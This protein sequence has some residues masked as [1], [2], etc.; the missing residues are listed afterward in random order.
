VSA[1]LRLIAIVALFVIVVV[2]LSVGSGNRRDMSVPEKVLVEVL[3]TFQEGL[4]GSA[5]S[6]EDLWRGYF[7]LIGLREENEALKKAQ[8]RLRGQVDQLREAGQANERL[9]KLLNFKSEND[10]T[11]L[12][13][14][15]I[16]WD[17]SAWFKSV[18]INRGSEDGLRPGL[19]VV[20]DEGVIGRVV[21]VSPRF[22]KVLLMIDYN[23]SIDA[24]VR[25]TRVRGILA[26]RSEKTCLLKYVLKNDEVS[27]DD[28]L[29]TS[30]LD[31][32]F[33]GGLTLGTVSRVKAMGPAIF[34]EVDV[35]PA[36]DF[37]RI[38]E[39]LVLI[40]EEPLF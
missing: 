26:G 23:S 25:R 4:M 21:G 31:G 36:V 15:V 12:G 37:K 17:P 28:V 5:R 40:R 13:A 24:I 29:V 16:S 3:A 20:T 18:I 8:A 27:K 6:V 1:R 9:R 22:A 35:T 2:A 10:Y 7:F 32:I 14:R 33:P 11:V 39:V 19:P 38:E 30:G 34:L